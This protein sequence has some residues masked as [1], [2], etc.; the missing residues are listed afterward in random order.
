LVANAVLVLD[1]GCGAPDSPAPRI[2]RPKVAGA[3]RRG[4]E[5]GGAGAEQVEQQNSGILAQNR[6]WPV[7]AA[8]T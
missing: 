5:A 6:R 7:L 2:L 3:V 4:S 8:A 1:V